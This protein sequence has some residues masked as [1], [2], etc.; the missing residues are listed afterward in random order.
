M[1]ETISRTRDPQ[2]P[3]SAPIS[4]KEGQGANYTPPAELNRIDIFRQPLSFLHGNPITKFMVKGL[5]LASSKSV[6]SI[7]GNPDHIS[8]KNDP[9][10]A[11]LNHNQRIEAVLIPAL[12]Y[13]YRLGKPIHFMADWNWLLMPGIR[14]MYRKSGTICIYRKDIKPKFLNVL[15]PLYREKEP[16]FDRALA[17]LKAGSPV[18]IFPEGTVNRDP[19]RLMRGLPGAAQMAMASGAPIVPMGLSFP[20]IEAGKPIP[21]G[22]SMILHIGEPLPAPELTG[23]DRIDKRTARDFHASIMGAVADLCGKTWSPSANKRR[24]YVV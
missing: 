19:D 4:W 9:F 3:D 22:A 13:F 7:E 20:N 14:L 11:V 10:I 8:S 24:R 17:R 16:A 21:D 2:F 1:L 23:E 6:L 15:K 12:L 5:M 18:G